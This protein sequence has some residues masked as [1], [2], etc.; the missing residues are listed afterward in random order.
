VQPLGIALCSSSS[1]VSLKSTHT[2][3]YFLKIKFLS[4]QTNLSD[5]VVLIMTSWYYFL[6]ALCEAVRQAR[7]PTTAVKRNINARSI[8]DGVT[9]FLCF[10]TQ[11]SK[12]E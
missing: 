1:T 9:D 12:D 6:A 10:I 3:C 5:A 4:V 7:S 8:R 2:E 11:F